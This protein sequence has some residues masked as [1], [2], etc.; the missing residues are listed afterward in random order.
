MLKETSLSVIEFPDFQ[1][2]PAPLLDKYNLWSEG[3]TERKAR[4]STPKLAENTSCD[5]KR[6]QK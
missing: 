1:S 6:N 5:A 3:N 2:E 4:L